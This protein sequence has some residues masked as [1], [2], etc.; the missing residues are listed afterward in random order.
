MKR[1]IE[2]SDRVIKNNIE[3][4]YL[5][6]DR[7]LRKQGKASAIVSS[8]DA[9][10]G[11][12]RLNGCQVPESGA[13]SGG[14]AAQLLISQFVVSLTGTTYAAADTSDYTGSHTETIIG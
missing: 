5:A 7:K 6:S 8:T 4:Y 14:N 3:S 10:A 2:T 11:Q 13:V 12:F 9:V 1:V